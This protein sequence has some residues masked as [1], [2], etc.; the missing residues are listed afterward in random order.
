M[1]LMYNKYT[2]VEKKPHNPHID[3]LEVNSMSYIILR[4]YLVI[5]SVAY[6]IMYMIFN[7]INHIVNQIILL[8]I[9]SLVIMMIYYN[10]SYNIAEVKYNKYEKSHIE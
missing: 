5:A 4:I 6:L 3:E 1:N 7:N 9:I 8:V 2:S 10:I